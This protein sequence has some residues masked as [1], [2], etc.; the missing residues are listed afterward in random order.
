MKMFRR[1]SY[2][3][4]A[5][6]NHFY[7]GR[8]WSIP[9]DPDTRKVTAK[10]ILAD[11]KCMW[12]GAPLLASIF[13]T[14]DLEDQFAHDYFYE[15]LERIENLPKPEGRSESWWECQVEGMVNQIDVA[16]APKP[17]WYHHLR[18]YLMRFPTVQ[19]LGGV[20]ILIVGLP[21]QRF[22]DSLPEDYGYH[23]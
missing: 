13:Y 18:N 14:P 3:D 4:Y 6:M 12:D 10:A 17:R 19:F 9:V 2:R 20:Y 7:R 16:K 5:L 22:Y 11:L 15:E 8:V 1:L 23:A 21:E